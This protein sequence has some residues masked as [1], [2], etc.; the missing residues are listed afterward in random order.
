MAEPVDS[1]LI[2]VVDLHKSFSDKKVLNGVNL[3]VHKGRIT[4]V[5]G[6]SGTGKSVLVKHFVGLL[7]PDRGKIL[8]EGEDTSEFREEDWLKVRRRY[9]LVFQHPT[10]FDSMS[11][12]ENVAFPLVKRLRVPRKEALERAMEFL[13]HVGMH[14]KASLMPAEV[15]PPEQKKVA[16]ARAL[17]LSPECAILDEPTTGLD[18]EA[19]RTIDEL[20]RKLARE[21]GKTVVVVSHD[22]R[23]IL[24]VADTIVFLYKG[25]VRFEGTPEQILESA[26]PVVAQFMRGAADGPLEA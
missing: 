25:R 12:I 7:R 19:S 6:T 24:G 16:V 14:D 15:S 2:R 3:D 26:D 22:L 20:I 1:R 18:I 17:T 5:I 23:S 13:R 4:Y 21:H 8:I 10:L 9:A 11:I